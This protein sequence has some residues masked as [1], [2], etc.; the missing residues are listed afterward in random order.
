MSPAELPTYT[1]VFPSLELY[2]T[3]GD[4]CERAPVL[5]SHRRLSCPAF[6]D[7]IAVSLDTP[8][9]RAFW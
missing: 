1:R 9:C 8:L 7:V 4:D 3:T 2:A 6:D 5:A